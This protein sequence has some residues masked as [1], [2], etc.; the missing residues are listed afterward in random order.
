MNK[1]IKV[2]VYCLAYNHGKYIRKTL[3][4][5]V[6]QKTNFQYEVIV[7]D[8]AS[9]DDTADIIKEFS[10]Q[11]PDIFVPIFQKKN[12]YS[13]NV[14]ILYEFIYPKMR[15]KYVAVCEGDDYWTDVEKLQKQFNVMEKYE[16]VSICTHAVQFISEE[17]K[18]ID[19][20][21]PESGINITEGLLKKD[22]FMRTV[23]MT[24][25]P[26]HTSSFFFRKKILDA[27]MK[28]KPE[29]YSL[30]PTG[31]FAVLCYAATFGGCYFINNVMSHYRVG[32]VGS[33]T[34]RIK[35]D[36]SKI[37]NRYERGINALKGLD[38]YTN[39]K[40][41]DDITYAVERDII[42]INQVN[43]TYRNL[44]K[45]LGCI[46]GNSKIKYLILGIIDFIFPNCFV[47][48]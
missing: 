44:L 37:C 28:D 6:N 1:D 5:F 27:Y 48:L 8:D 40:Y 21:C 25:Y 36:K 39:Y 19:G 47:K 23:L 26:F 33:W 13:Q 3:E 9:T 14:R 46:R 16:E 10:Y 43:R 34:E 2:S 7:H 15:G 32:A 42:T 41:H 38:E 35:M 31:D 22:E 4:G 29:F 45:Y 11:Y 12:Q 20:R 18:L 30:F 17:G 24:G